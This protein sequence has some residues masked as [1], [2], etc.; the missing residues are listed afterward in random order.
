MGQTRIDRYLCKWA[1]ETWSSKWTDENETS[2]MPNDLLEMRHRR[3]K[4]EGKNAGRGKNR[5]KQMK[6]RHGTSVRGKN[7]QLSPDGVREKN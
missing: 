2:S 5:S 3:W 7:E 1:M 6:Q 4:P